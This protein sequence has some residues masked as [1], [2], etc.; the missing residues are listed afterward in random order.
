MNA[1]PIRFESAENDLIESMLQSQEEVLTDLD[2]LFNR[3]D[4]VIA[5][6]TEQR[7][8]ETEESE[9]LLQFGQQPAAANAGSNPEVY[10]P[11]EK[12]A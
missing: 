1:Q 8:R 11:R 12:A 6:L 3:I 4:T 7:K 5:E 9:T 10:G 2:D